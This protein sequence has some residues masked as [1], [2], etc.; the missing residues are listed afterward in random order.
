MNDML[1]D[2]DLRPLER[3]FKSGSDSG[4]TRFNFYNMGKREEK[5]KRTNKPAP[6]QVKLSDEARAHV[7]EDEN[8]ENRE[9]KL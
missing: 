8:V 7:E 1:G 4:G 3:S 2:S 6:V 5:K 9:R